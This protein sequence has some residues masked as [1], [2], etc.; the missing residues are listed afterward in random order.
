MNEKEWLEEILEEASADVRTWPNWLKDNGV[1]M[2][3]K[4]YQFPN[5]PVAKSGTSVLTYKMGFFVCPTCGCAENDIWLTCDC[6]CHVHVEK[7]NG[8]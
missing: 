5:H 1:D 6:K 7:T 8:S 3:N 4:Q 2:E